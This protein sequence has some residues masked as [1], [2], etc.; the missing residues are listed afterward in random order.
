MQGSLKG[1]ECLQMVRADVETRCDEYD[2]VA[3]YTLP[4][5]Q[6]SGKYLFMPHA[7]SMKQRGG[8][9]PADVYFLDYDDCFE[10]V[11][12]VS[13]LV[14]QI[15]DKSER[16]QTI[17]L[18]GVLC[19]AKVFA[20]AII[21][22]HVRERQ[23]VLDKIVF[24][25][26]NGVI[27]PEDLKT[28]AFNAAKVLPAWL[29]PIM[30]LVLRQAHKAGRK[31]EAESYGMLNDENIISLNE[32]A[33]ERISWRL[34]RSQ[35]EAMSAPSPEFDK[36]IRIKKCVGVFSSEDD[37]IDNGFSYMSLTHLFDDVMYVEIDAGHST[38]A[39]QPD[40]WRRKFYEVW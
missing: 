20:H 26:I 24:N 34:L 8:L 31:K 29:D 37:R 18:D 12:A 25:S 4:G 3:T 16:Y 28:T 5:V 11:G 13:E 17:Y 32:D 14:D 27:S 10:L 6:N 2:A 38:L 33:N 23:D 15:V 22:L 36:P 9:V 7:R 30:T 1:L 35:V 40:I 19:G 21:E 39:Y